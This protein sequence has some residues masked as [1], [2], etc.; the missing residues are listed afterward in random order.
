VTDPWLR[1]VRG[2]Y[3]FDRRV[4][5]A[6]LIVV[7][8]F[9]AAALV[10]SGFVVRCVEQYCPEDRPIGCVN[11]FVMP[12]PGGFVCMVDDSSWCEPALLRPGE[13]VGCSPGF[14]QRHAGFYSLLIVL[15]GFVANH[16]MHNIRRVR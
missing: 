2:G 4:F 6:V 11:A 9:V 1:S 5:W 8:I 14:F 12:G 13:R 3:V 15:A 16:G 10:E 7:M